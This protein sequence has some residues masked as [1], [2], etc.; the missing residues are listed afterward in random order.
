YEKETEPVCTRYGLGVINYYALASGFL[1]GKYRSEADLGQSPRGH[2]VKDYLND[3][4]SRILQALDEA[5]KQ[6]STTAASISLAWLMA[7]PSIT[8]PIASATKLEQLEDLV[9]AAGL[10]LD[11][12]TIKKL[13]EASAY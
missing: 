1:T 9:K 7:R 13:D 11:Q 5:A 4:G 3:R 8:A 12:A 6:Y 10:K 2:G